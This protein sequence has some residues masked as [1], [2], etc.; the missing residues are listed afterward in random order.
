MTRAD[1][2]A[3]AAVLRDTNV[4]VLSDE[5][6]CS[7]TYGKE[8]HACFAELPGMQ[9]RT[10]VVDGFSKSYA[11]TGWRLGWAMGPKELMT[12]HLQG[13][14]VRHH[15]RADHRAVCGHRGHPHRRG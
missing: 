13:A 5:I 1:L 15:V 14:S 10:I 3:I 2:E 8:P 4:L 12:P 6:Y 7:L 11:M 9:E